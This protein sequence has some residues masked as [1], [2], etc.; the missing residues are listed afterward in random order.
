MSQK[1]HAVTVEPIQ[2]CNTV[3][4]SQIRTRTTR[5]NQLRD[6]NGTTMPPPLIAGYIISEFTTSIAVIFSIYLH[7]VSY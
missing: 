1:L 5:K 3:S 7:E 6:E 4:S 2:R